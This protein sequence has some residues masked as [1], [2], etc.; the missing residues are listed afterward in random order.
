MSLSRARR[1]FN[2]LLALI[3]VIGVW[4][5]PGVNLLAQINGIVVALVIAVLSFPR[6]PKT[7][8]YGRWD[9]F[10]A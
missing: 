10:V 3:L 9:R 5:L 1:Y 2:L 4:I 6:G 8:T 7:E